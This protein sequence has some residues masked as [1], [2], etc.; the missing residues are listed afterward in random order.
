MTGF[1]A[2]GQVAPAQ[3]GAPVAIPTQLTA[4]V[5]V[6]SALAPGA[7]ARGGA[8][9]TAGAMVALEAA[10]WPIAVGGHA[11]FS[12]Q[13]WLVFAAAPDAVLAG[14]RSVTAGVMQASG[15]LSAASLVETPAVPRSW[16]RRVRA[17]PRPLLLHVEPPIGPPVAPV[18]ALA[19]RTDHPARGVE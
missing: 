2:P 10:T 12:A 1:A 8:R 15:A 18:R 9:L 4:G 16:A 19:L 11:T 13:R 17:R 3:L 5:M 6:A 14:G 7:L